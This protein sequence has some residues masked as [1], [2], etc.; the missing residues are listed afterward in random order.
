MRVVE[1]MTK[2]HPGNEPF[3]EPGKNFGKQETSFEESYNESYNESLHNNDTLLTMTKTED[4]V[5]LPINQIIKTEPSQCYEPIPQAV[6]FHEP[7]VPYP[8]VTPSCHDLDLKP[9]T[10][11]TSLPSVIPLFPESSLSPQPSVTLLAQPSITPMI[12]DQQ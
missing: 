10:T 11:D 3:L 5:N 6:M 1:H 2:N 7:H 8:T 9:F 12:M 4:I